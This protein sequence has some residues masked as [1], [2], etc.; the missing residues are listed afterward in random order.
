MF[1]LYK[2]RRP[3][4]ILT[5]ASSPPSLVTFAADDTMHIAEVR[6]PWELLASDDSTPAT[7]PRQSSARNRLA[8]R[9][10]YQE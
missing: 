2:D 7:L 3:R 8:R 6:R 5:I 1:S 4:T 10:V 9:S